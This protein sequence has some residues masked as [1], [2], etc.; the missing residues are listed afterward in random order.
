C[1]QADEFSPS[2]IMRKRDA[3]FCLL[4]LPAFMTQAVC[5]Q[6]KKGPKPN[7]LARKNDFR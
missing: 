7:T 6:R 3:T 1:Y 2:T 5:G 4:L